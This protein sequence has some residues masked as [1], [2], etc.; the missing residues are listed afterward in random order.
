MRT[1][2]IILALFQLF[3]VV[4]FLSIHLSAPLS[5]SALRL[6]YLVLFSPLVIW[7]RVLLLHNVC[8]ES[9]R[10]LRLLLPHQLLLFDLALREHSAETGFILIP[11]DP[12]ATRWR[13]LISLGRTFPV[14]VTEPMMGGLLGRCSGFWH[15]AVLRVVTVFKPWEPQISHGSFNT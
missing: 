13:N 4:S 3:F 15:R 7:T 6:P 9:A 8:K 10:S 14:T 2:S 1:F 11:G 5:P 12:I